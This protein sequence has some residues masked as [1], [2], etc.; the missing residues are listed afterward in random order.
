MKTDTITELK[1]KNTFLHE[2]VN[3]QKSE[4]ATKEVKYQRLPDEKKML[5]G[6]ASS[7]SSS[8]GDVMVEEGIYK[9]ILSKIL[10]YVVDT[11][12]SRRRNNNNNNDCNNDDGNETS[13]AAGQITTA[14]LLMHL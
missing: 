9:G 14:T 5:K 4:L 13:M 6:R 7:S 8:V 1:F 2:L 12:T 11:T 3:T 10:E